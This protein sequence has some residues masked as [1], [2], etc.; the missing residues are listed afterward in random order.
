ME[1]DAQEDLGSG[2][3]VVAFAGPWS[4]RGEAV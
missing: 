1:K 3:G 2:L 4:K